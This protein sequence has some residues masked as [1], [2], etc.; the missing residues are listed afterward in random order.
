[1]QIFISI[2]IN[3]I[4]LAVLLPLFYIYIA[5]KLREKLEKEAVSRAQA[6]IEDIVK[7][8]NNT[9]LS[10]IA[11]LE[12]VIMRSRDASEELNNSY[13]FYK[14]IE[15]S[16]FLKKI[17]YINNINTDSKTSSN[18]IDYEKNKINRNTAYVA[19]IREDKKSIENSVPETPKNSIQLIANDSLDNDIKK[20]YQSEAIINLYNSGLSE[21]EISNKLGLSITE[22]ELAINMSKHN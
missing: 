17:S 20:V 1:M 22:I 19:K 18:I 7:E 14:E 10:N 21:V 15:K 4:I 8:F 5:Y 3:L 6:E 13:E 16:D 11:L 9:A 2:I 12:D